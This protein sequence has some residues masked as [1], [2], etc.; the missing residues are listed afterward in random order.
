MKRGTYKKFPTDFRE[1]LR[2]K[3]KWKKIA[4]TLWKMALGGYEFTN[5][6]G[7]KIIAEPNLEC[8]KTIIFLSFGK[9]PDYSE[10][11]GQA[12]ELLEK[13][14]EFSKLVIKPKLITESK[15]LSSLSVGENTL[16][17]NNEERTTNN[18]N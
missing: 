4:Q 8:I 6:N 16:L 7:Q 17:N 10:T 5:Y 15:E 13:F 11:D 3:T 9:Y 1:M 18:N 12:K 2:T 14:S